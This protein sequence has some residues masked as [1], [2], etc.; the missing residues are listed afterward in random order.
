MSSKTKIDAADRLRSYLLQVIEYAA[1]I[2]LAGIMFLT[3]VDVLSRYLFRRPI[4]ASLELTEMAMQVMIYLC[5]AVAVAGNNH[6]KV[7]LL[8]SLFARVPRL[9]RWVGWMSTMAFAIILGM[10]GL[11]MFAL[12]Q[13]KASDIT[14]VLRLPIAP[15]AWAIGV[16]LFISALLAAWSIVRP[17][18][19][20]NESEHD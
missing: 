2:L 7:T 12:A 18:R 10:L 3:L 5:I 13:G 1:A 19:G 16:S 15:V 17:L 20:G 14:P 11:A 9:E 8:D 6:I 4:G